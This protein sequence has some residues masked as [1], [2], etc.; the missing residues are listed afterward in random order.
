MISLD[1]INKKFNIIYCDCPWTYDDEC[2]AGE[3][4]AIYKYPLMT[5]DEL[6][7]LPVGEIAEDDSV[8]FLWVTMPKLN[9]IFECGLINSWGFTYKTNA[10]TWVKKNKKGRGWFTGMGRWTR[11]NAELCLLATKG[12]PKRINA[13]V[14]SVIDTPIQEHSKKPQET[15]DRIVRLCG[16][17][18]RIELFA[19]QASPGWAAWGNEIGMVYT[20]PEENKFFS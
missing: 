6:K 18:P 15:R 20:P 17:L 19:R 8:M 5:M 3:R 4:G 13:D 7:K 11:S 2:S 1:Q 16:D 14:H 10:F 9:E 12:N